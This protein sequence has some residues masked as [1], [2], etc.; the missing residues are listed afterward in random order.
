MM[1]LRGF[2]MLE[3]AVTLAIAG[4]I[5]AAAI[6]ATVAIQR[7]FTAARQRLDQTNDARLVMEHVLERVRMAGG[8]RVRPWQAVAVTCAAD[9]VHQLP[10]CAA[11]QRRLN[12]LELEATGQGTISGTSKTAGANT[13]NFGIAAPGGVCPITAA[14]GYVGPTPVVIVPPESRLEEQG[15]PAWVVAR[16]TPTTTCGCLMDKI[17]R[18]GV[19]ILPPGTAS[20]S[21]LGGTVS[22]GHV[23]TYYVDSENTTLM[24]LK[25]FDESG[26]AGRT[27]LAPDVVAFDVRFGYDVDNDG[28]VDQYAVTP[29][30]GKMRLLRMVKVG[31]AVGRASKDG[32]TMPA[33][34]FGSQVSGEGQRAVS[35]DGTGLLRATGVFQ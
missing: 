4:I 14:N 24:L 3:L 29:V 25:D 33:F 22:R 10:A 11:G 15:G 19:T 17:S 8:G 27:S 1:K 34:L 35:L 28:E 9:A 5:S 31:V 23:S 20:P 13:F 32:T 21:F 2:S 16:C 7:S 26:D 18:G 30:A 12:V 6:S